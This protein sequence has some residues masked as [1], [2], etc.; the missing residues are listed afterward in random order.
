MTRSRLVLSSLLATLLAAWLLLPG[1]AEAQ[2]R[3]GTLIMLVQPEPPTLAAYQ[4]TSGPIGTPA[5]RSNRAMG[6]KYGTHRGTRVV[7]FLAAI[8]CNLLNSR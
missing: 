3:G 7:L 2:K 5:A 1:Q 6:L 8:T 4:S